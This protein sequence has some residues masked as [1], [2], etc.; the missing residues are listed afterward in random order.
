MAC[1]SWIYKK[2]LVMSEELQ[3]ETLFVPSILH[4]DYIIYFL[5]SD[6]I[7]HILTQGLCRY[8]IKVLVDRNLKKN[9]FLSLIKSM[10]FIRKD[11]K[12]PE[13]LILTFSGNPVNNN[14]SP[15]FRY[16]YFMVSNFQKDTWN[17]QFWITPCE[18][19]T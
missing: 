15:D 4:F 16:L 19:V 18:R 13:I 2:S 8:I 3:L 17:I 9:F 11:M 12:W 1:S 5:F 6:W 10:F 7:G 14:A